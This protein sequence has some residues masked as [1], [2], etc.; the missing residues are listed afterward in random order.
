MARFDDCLP[1]ILKQEGGWSND[2][3][4]PGGPTNKGI[5]LRVYAAYLGR[6]P[7]LDVV[8][9]LKNIPDDHLRDIYRRNYWQLVRGDELPPGVDLAVFDYGVN[10]GPAT[11]IRKL[12]QCL[13]AMTG[14]PVKVDGHLGPVTMEAI[15][16]VDHRELISRF[17]DSRRAYL[18]S[19]RTFWRFGRGWMRRC[20]EIEDE[21]LL[22]VSA[23]AA[24][25]PR[26]PRLDA[27]STDVGAGSGRATTDETTTMT[28]STTGHA[29]SAIGTGSGATLGMETAATVADLNAKGKPWT[30]TDVLLALA[31][32]PSFW[33]ALGTLV[34]AVYVW[35]ERRRH[36][37]EGR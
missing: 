17:M 23:A 32:K 26:A 4:D 24:G 8:P 37:Q 34:A 33:I 12:Q 14:R 7:T 31:S 36:M 35:L 3:I 15:R 9:L 16:C 20:D 29:A 25:F 1:R 27:S 11:S 19:L 18:R 6:Q 10:S 5:I 30:I 21:A 13:A 22:D 2:P 28:A